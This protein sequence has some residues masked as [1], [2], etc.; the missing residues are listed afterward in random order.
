MGYFQEEADRQK[1]KIQECSSCAPGITGRSGRQDWGKKENETR[2][3]FP[4]LRQ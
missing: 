4:S 3:L 2:L 1:Q